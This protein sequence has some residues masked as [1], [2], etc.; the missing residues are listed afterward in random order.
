M[1]VVVVVVVVKAMDYDGTLTLGGIHSPP[2]PSP[3]SSLLP[4]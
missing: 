4:P 2:F 1:G 3:L